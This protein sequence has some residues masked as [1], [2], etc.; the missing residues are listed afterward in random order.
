LEL[1]GETVNNTHFSNSTILLFFNKIDIFKEKLKRV[2]LNNW[3]KDYKG[4]NSFE[5]GI[6]YISQKYLDQNKGE[7][8]RIHVYRTMATSSTEVKRVF[9][10]SKN[11]L[12]D[13]YKKK[14]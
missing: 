6:Q 2:E 12:V 7:P 8:G 13:A 3:F 4:E 10:E 5:E 11:V 14:Q 9:E 1:F